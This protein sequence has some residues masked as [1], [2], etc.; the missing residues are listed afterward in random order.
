MEFLAV[1]RVLWR[2]R[3]AV[4]AGGLVAIALALVFAS[5]ARSTVGVASMRVMLDTPRSQTVETNPPNFDTLPSRAALLADLTGANPSRQRIANDM[6]IATKSLVV[7]SPALSIAPVPA[8][9]PRHALDV[10]SA[11]PEPYALL[12]RAIN[13]L[14]IIAIDARAPSGPQAAKLATA[15]AT[16]LKAAAP[17]EFAHEAD[18]FVVNEVAP[19]RSHEVV[20]GP[21]RMIA[22]IIALAVFGL[23]CA[24]ITLVAGVSRARGSL[25]RIRAPAVR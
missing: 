17:S 10:A 3:I 11:V 20:D 12:I 23:W 25:L 19:V 24:C 6:G 22:V 9:L 16:A 21:R 13:P 4:A 18:R 7:S 2:C 1:A 8:P 15:A 5:G 14:P